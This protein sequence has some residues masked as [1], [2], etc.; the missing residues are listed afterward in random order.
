MTFRNRL[1]ARIAPAGSFAAAWSQSAQL[2]PRLMLVT[3]LLVA[4]LH[5]ANALFIYHFYSTNA[6]HETETR[7]ATA[8]RSSRPPAP[9]MQSVASRSP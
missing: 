8:T 1:K 6:A 3:I 2:A 4:L 5:A 7:D 9:C